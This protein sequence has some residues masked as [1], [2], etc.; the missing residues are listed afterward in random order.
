[1]YWLTKVWPFQKLG[2]RVY[3]HGKRSNKNISLTFDDGPSEQTFEILKLL[4]KYNA[5]ATFFIL[6]KKVKNYKSEIKAIQ[7]Q[8]S[9]IGNHS[10]SHKSLLFKTKRIIFEEIKKNENEL[11][12]LK[13]KTS[14]IRPPHGNFGINLL[15][16]AKLLNKKII[17]WDID[18]NDWSSPGKQKVIDYILNKVKPGSIIDLHEYAE[19]IGPNEDLIEILK[20]LIPLLKNKGYKLVTISELYKFKNS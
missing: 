16:I 12:N 6:G 20:E 13:I 1:M 19:G 2:K 5:K 14:L 18:P 10:Y 9:E 7:K 11:K 17:L 3:F 15:S 4:D 8:G